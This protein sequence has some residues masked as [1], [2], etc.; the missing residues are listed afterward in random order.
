MPVVTLSQEV[1]EPRFMSIQSMVQQLGPARL[2]VQKI[3]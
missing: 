2:I 3:V 1:P